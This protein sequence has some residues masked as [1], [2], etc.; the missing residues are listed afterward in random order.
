MAT[1]IHQLHYF[2]LALQ[3][4]AS[5]LCHGQMTELKDEHAILPQS[6]SRGGQIAVSADQAGSL[7]SVRDSILEP[8]THQGDR[9]HR[10]SSD[11]TSVRRRDPPLVSALQRAW[12]RGAVEL[13]VEGYTKVLIECQKQQ[14]PTATVALMSSDSQQAHCFR[15]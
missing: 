6:L 8:R 9:Q 11:W 15:F 2:S 10:E 7:E 5:G 1:R 13:A 3:L 4:I 12:K 14:S